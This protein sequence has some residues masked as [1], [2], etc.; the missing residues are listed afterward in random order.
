MSVFDAIE[1][2]DADGSVGDSPGSESAVGYAGSGPGA[3]RVVARAFGGVAVPIR[4]VRM[5]YVVPLRVTFLVR[6][7]GSCVS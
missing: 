1:D 3:G 5:G 2:R 6:S 7:G 4:S